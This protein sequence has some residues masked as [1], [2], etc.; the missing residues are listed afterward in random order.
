MSKKKYPIGGYAPGNY[1][2]KC[3]VCGNNFQGDKR[4]VECEPCAVK[5][6][7]AFD[8]LSKEERVELIIRNAEVVKQ[9]LDDLRNLTTNDTTTF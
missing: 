7:E 1:Y 8:S 3:C 4:A 2:C 9:L 5:A 6:M